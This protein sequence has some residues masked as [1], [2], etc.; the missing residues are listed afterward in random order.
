MQTGLVDS[1][2]ELSS[3]QEK[4]PPPPPPPPPTGTKAPALPEPKRTLVGVTE[5]Q[6]SKVKQLLTIKE[7]IATYPIDNSR[8]KAAAIYT[9]RDGDGKPEVIFVHTAPDAATTT[10]IPLLKLDVVTN[11]GESLTNRFSI[12][13]AGSYV[14]TN[15]YD[16][17][18]VRFYVGDITGDGR[19]EIIVTS[20]IGASIGATLQAFSFNGESLKRN[21][22][23]RGASF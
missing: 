3:D 6:L 16:Q 15:I 1:N 20:A 17:S 11:N 13:L 9:D 12:Q 8:E 19:A 4:A 7:R 18:P 5:E 22:K 23:N 10:N 21:C 2:R 14:Y